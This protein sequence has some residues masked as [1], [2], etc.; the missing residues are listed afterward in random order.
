MTPLVAV[1][2]FAALTALLLGAWQLFWSRKGTP[3]H[4]IAGRAWVAA[5]L[6]VA[7]S[8]FGIQ[9]LRPGH[10]SFLHILSVVTI[11]TVSLGVW[12][13]T[14]GNIASHRGNMT[15]SWIGLTFAFVFAVAIPERAVPTFVVTQ[16][17]GAAFALAAILMTT[18]LVIGLARVLESR[19]QPAMA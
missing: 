19:T 7:V 16:P 18:A 4:R 5:M 8:S 17:I 14:R 3:A 1:H 2:A 9:D 12:D 15:G 6:F 10:F 11:V 13:A